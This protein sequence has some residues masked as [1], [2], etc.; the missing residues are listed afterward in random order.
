[1]LH[2]NTAGSTSSLV[3]SVSIPGIALNT[4]MLSTL[5]SSVVNVFLNLCL[6]PSNRL[7]HPPFDL[8]ALGSSLQSMN[9]LHLGLN[10]MRGFPFTSVDM[11]SFD[12][13]ALKI[14]S[15]SLISLV[16]S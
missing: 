2:H 13:I 6:V 15:A 9:I 3:R 5:D 8:F 1:M 11:T 12:V 10:S 16:A 7:S 14:G 4:W